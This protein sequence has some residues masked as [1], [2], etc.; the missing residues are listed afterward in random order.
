MANMNTN[1]KKTKEDT[2]ITVS[3]VGETVHKL[4]AIEEL[5]GIATGTYLGESTAYEERSAESEIKRIQRLVADVPAE[6]SEYVLKIAAIGRAGNMISSPLAVLT[7]CF[8]D[9]KYRGPAVGG[10]NEESVINKYVPQVV[11]RAKDITEILATQTSLYPRPTDE[12]IKAAKLRGQKLAATPIPRRLLKTL[13]KRL[14]AFD[15]FQISKGLSKN[16]IFTMADAIRL[17]HPT[18]N[19]PIYKAVLDGTA[20]VG[21]GKEQLTS[22]LSSEE[23][24]TEK[25]VQSLENSSL[26][27]I[28]NNL[29]SML[30]NGEMTEEAIKIICDKLGNPDVVRK[31]RIMPYKLFNAYLMVKYQRGPEAKE[32]S[33]ALS[34]AIDA[35]VENVADI[36]GYSAVFVD[37]SGSM[38]AHVASLSSTTRKVLA[39]FLGAIAAKKAKSRVYAFATHCAEIEVVSRNEPVVSITQRILQAN[40]GGATYLDEAIRTVKE[41]GEK[42]DNLILLTD[43]DCYHR[44]NNSFAFGTSY[45]RTY[46]S[47]INACIKAGVFKRIFVNDLCGNDFSIVNTDDYRKNLVSGFTERY[48]DSI[49]NTILLQKN[50]GNIISLI[51]ILYDMYF[52]AAKAAK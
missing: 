21:N 27:Q 10:N 33:E 39:A 46:D 36:D 35:S 18:D 43:S 52:P 30:R 47:E 19:K 49:N 9:E 22:A 31:S 45:G 6:Y 23:R 29:V 14:E 25:V 11:C 12:E 32:I 13:R 42:F 2:N 44:T 48:I 20:K 3:H 50:A 17:L 24:T 41:I 15:E 7:A 38:D 34:N 1:K 8:N 40:V 51:D 4:N 28:V 26:S 37:L 16:S 5:F